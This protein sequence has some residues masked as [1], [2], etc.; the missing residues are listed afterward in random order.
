MPRKGLLHLPIRGGK[1]LA[2]NDYP[3]SLGKLMKFN[4]N[5]QF[6][7]FVIVAFGLFAFPSGASAQ[8]EPGLPGSVEYSVLS[9]NQFW[10]PTT[11]PIGVGSYVED[12]LTGRLNQP[13]GRGSIGIVTDTGFDLDYNVMAATVDF[14]RNYSVG[15]IFPQL[16]PIQIVPE[17][18]AAPLL[19]LGMLGFV[20]CRWR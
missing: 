19:L 15:I 20:S 17:P 8:I 7:L 1:M 11:D 4:P 16:S 9:N 2:A 14:G 13:D 6:E 10:I 12:L 3:I 5:A 18:F